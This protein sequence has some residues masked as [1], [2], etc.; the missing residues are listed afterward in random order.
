MTMLKRAALLA[1]ALAPT[2][3]M[4]QDDGLNIAF[5]AASSQNGFNQ[6]V[7]AGIEAAA[8]DYD[9]VTTEIFDGE[10]SAQVQFSQVEDLVAGGRF[11]ALIVTP[12]DTV[13]IATALEQ[14][15]AAGVPVAATLFP[16]GPDLS[17]MEPQ[18]DGLVTTVAADPSIGARIQAEAVVEHCEGIDPCRVVVLIGQ[19][20]FPFD[21]LRYETFQEVLGEH[22][23]IEIVATGEGNYSPEES[24]VAMQDILQANPDID[25]V[26][27]NA[28]QHLMGAEIA[29][30][31]AGIDVSDVY[32]IG[33]GLNQ[34]TVD[35]I[36]QGL[37]DA[38]LAQFPASM[39][40]AALDAVVGH[41]RG[42]EVPT[43]INERELREDVPAIVDREWLEAHPDFEAEW[44]G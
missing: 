30:D 37:Y 36:R 24:L 9:N 34:I 28:D 23:N 13:G 40:A 15:T 17:Q 18:V 6:A 14:A 31:D 19:L 5:L 10:F 12:N 22:D 32:L 20:V 38:S 2:A 8:A 7:Y 1:A 43:W 27:S 4:A 3:A 11:D 33:G 42:E 16:I 44:Q 35:G 26:L 39:G 41:L 29:L 21:N 25:V